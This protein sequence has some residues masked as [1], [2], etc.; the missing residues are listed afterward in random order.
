MAHQVF[1]KTLGSG[2]SIKDILKEETKN[3][4]KSKSIHT[5][6]LTVTSNVGNA[7]PK[8][9]NFSSYILQEII[10]ELSEKYGADYIANVLETSLVS[11]NISSNAPKSKPRRESISNDIRPGSPTKNPLY[12]APTSPPPARSRYKEDT[13]SFQTKRTTRSNTLTESYSDLKPMRR[14]LEKPLNESRPQVDVDT[15][16]TPVPDKKSPMEIDRPMPIPTNKSDQ[17]PKKQRISMLGIGDFFVGDP[18]SVDTL[19]ADVGK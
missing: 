1:S 15:E 17:G 13:Q 3:N 2:G 9:L 8:R 11:I 16:P 10:A 5:K 19:L 4:N 7:Q 6:Y 14:T 12:V 18:S